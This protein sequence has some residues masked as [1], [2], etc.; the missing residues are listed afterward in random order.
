MAGITSSTLFPESA[1]S[2]RRSSSRRRTR[3]TPDHNQ[4]GAQEYS[5]GNYSL[6]RRNNF[7]V[8]CNGF[9]SKPSPKRGK[10]A[11]SRQCTCTTR[12][13]S[14]LF[15]ART[16]NFRVQTRSPQT[17]SRATRSKVSPLNPLL[18]DRTQISRKLAEPIACTLSQRSLNSVEHILI[19][20]CLVLAG[21]NLSLGTNSP[22]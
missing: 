15:F 1:A 17:A 7:P 16:G 4:A 5:E 8:L 19:N 14:S 11:E 6:F 10:S 13:K 20:D 9:S 21:I 3:S 22:R 12:G 2:I 18:P